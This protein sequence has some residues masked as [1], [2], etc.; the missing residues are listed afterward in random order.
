MTGGVEVL[1]DTRDTGCEA[2]S[3]KGA[4]IL[5]SMETAQAGHIHIYIIYISN[6]YI[7]IYYIK[8]CIISRKNEG[9]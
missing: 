8:I 3:W 1:K 5:A 9:V 6:I 4:A 2:V 7:Y